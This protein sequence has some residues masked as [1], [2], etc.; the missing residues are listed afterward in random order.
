MF[1]TKS[2]DPQVVNR[3][4]IYTALPQAPTADHTIYILPTI[5][6]NTY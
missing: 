6:Q 3:S 1:Q 4:D 2:G 5:G